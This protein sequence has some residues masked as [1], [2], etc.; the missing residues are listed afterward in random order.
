MSIITLTRMKLPRQKPFSF[1]STLSTDPM[2]VPMQCPTS[3]VWNV[4]GM[5]WIWI[6]SAILS[7]LILFT[8]S[9]IF[10]LCRARKY[11]S[12]DQGPCSRTLSASSSFW[13]R[14]SAL[15][16]P[17]LLTSK[18]WFVFQIELRTRATDSRF[19][20]RFVKNFPASTLLLYDTGVPIITSAPS[21]SDSCKPAHLFKISSMSF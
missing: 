14:K 19:T 13:K 2:V 7:N 1:A 9:P 16:S 17:K 11:L 6:H 3:L 8:A 15:L 18:L 4:V 20:R 12:K 21:L 10:N 5:P